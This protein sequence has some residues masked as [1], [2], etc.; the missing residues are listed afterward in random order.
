MNQTVETI[1]RDQVVVPSD[2]PCDGDIF[3]KLPP[4]GHDPNS[5]ECSACPVADQCK[6]EQDK[7]QEAERVRIEAEQAEADKR[8][9]N[10]KRTRAR[11]FLE[12]LTDPDHEN[13]ITKKDLVSQM[14][15]RY[16]SSE[17]EAKF[18]TD[19]FSRLLMTFGWMEQTDNKLLKLTSVPPALISDDME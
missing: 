11:I 4:L 8:K 9:R 5:P 13:G 18:Q 6:A 10:A 3:G 19:M 1:E 16:G 17:A 14:W 15:E 7:L 12:I 2:S